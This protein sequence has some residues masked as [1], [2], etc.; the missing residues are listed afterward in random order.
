MI[1]LK[2]KYIA[3]NSAIFAAISPLSTISFANNA[4][5]PVVNLDPITVTSTRAP[6]KVSDVIAQTTVI[7]EQDLQRYQ[8]K[9]VLD[10]LKSQAGFNVKQDGGLG[11]SSNFY[12]R[13][14]DSKQVLV[15]IDGVPYQS[16]TLGTP[17][18]NLLSIAQVSRIEILHGASGSSIYGANAMGGVIQIFTKGND[19]T[20]NEDYS[21]AQITAG[22][23]S[24]DHF[25]V[26]AT[27]Q[28]ADADTKLSAGLNHT[29]TNGFNAVK[30]GSNKVDDN[31]GF[32]LYGAHLAASQKLSN[33]LSA[34]L[35]AY[36]NQSETEYD[37]NPWKQPP[38]P[39]SYSDQKNGAAN[40]YI[41]YKDD[42]ATTRF[43]QGYSM[44]YSTAYADGNND[45]TGSQFNTL[46]QNS[47]VDSNVKVGENSI[48]IAGA[49]YNSQK[50]NADTAYTKN[51]RN[52]KS[53]FAGY[54][55]AGD[56]WDLQ[57]NYRNANDS[58][59]GSNN[60]Y[61][62][63]AAV[64]PVE[65]L[66]IGAAYSTGF[67]APT[68]NELYWPSFGNPNLE[69]ETSRN[70]E[71]FVEYGNQNQR[72]RLTGY[73]NNIE[74][75]IAGGKNI[76]KADVK[77]I[78]L[79][80]DWNV[81]NVLFGAGY[82]YIDSENLDEKNKGNQLFYRP[83]HKG[84][85]Y[86]GYEGNNFD[87]RLEAQYVGE[88]YTDVSNTTKLD[89]YTLVNISGNYYVNDSLS[90]GLRVN[91]VTDEEYTISNQRGTEYATDGR[92]YFGSLTYTWF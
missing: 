28:Y 67:R 3:I 2:P 35:N 21:N 58:Q 85:A 59:Y 37:A 84:V 14:Y 23:G 15:L 38:Y 29:K 22:Y 43:T 46:I 50:V 79:T 87:T 41:E 88:H 48:L 11:T 45:K 10:V 20:G 65:G 19:I 56:V 4:N 6:S 71:V 91:N 40:V 17:A 8:G 80:S 54:Q 32:T 63:G 33:N 62:I 47:R 60:T 81:N 64:K 42:L 61:N 89:D 76:N 69:P 5:L 53:V 49:E 82:D 1:V 39:Y 9:T 36:Y 18:L 77:G 13:G 34:G 24:N 16:A 26:G 12:L 27:G 68:F 90:I 70:T 83:E 51:K 31:D 55:L 66:R 78:S 25:M 92:N 44:D 75:L 57:A 86:V 74:N 73:E 30:K 7:D 72:T 52:T